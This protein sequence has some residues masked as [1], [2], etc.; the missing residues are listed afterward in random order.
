MPSTRRS[1]FAS[2]SAMLGML[3]LAGVLCFHFPE[4]LTS[5]EFRQI[6]TE[7]FARNLLLVGLVC[8]FSLGTLAILRGRDRRVA[9]LGVGSA[10]LAVLLGGTDVQ[11]D[12]I[13]QTPYSLG[14][15]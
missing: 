5:R 14:L 10:T 8:A 13:D 12:G 15:D 3:S 1:W 6:Y 4:L 9:L 7:G 2:L 11:F